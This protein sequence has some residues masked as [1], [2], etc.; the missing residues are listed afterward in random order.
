MAFRSITTGAEIRAIPMLRS[1]GDRLTR[2]VVSTPRDAYFDVSTHGAANIPELA[3]RELTIRQHDELKATMA[4]FGCEVIDVP[5]FA[6]HPNSVFTRDV[7]VCTPGGHIK[8]RM[9]LAARRG[10]EGW[11][12]E[13]LESIGERC[14]GEIREPGTV[15]G[16]DIIL[17][18]AIAFVG[19]SERTNEEGARQLTG[20][21]ADMGLE[22]RTVWIQGYMHLGGAM[23]LIGPERVLCCRG[24]FPEG[25]FKGFDTIEVEPRGPST[26]NVI[27][28]QENEVIA[29]AAENAPVI[30][31]LEREAVR[32]HALDL[33]EFRKGAG[34]PTCLVLPVER[35]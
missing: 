3:D 17:A 7:A 12:S 29:N 32:V 4:E 35:R 1:E 9:G 30:R 23:S 33:S 15:E 24:V 10:E 28:L 31:R 8:L 34:G 26:G 5:E 18:G 27:C 14:V 6:G 11:M 22:V 20:M 13:A 21:L 19:V 2:V 25:L 16:G